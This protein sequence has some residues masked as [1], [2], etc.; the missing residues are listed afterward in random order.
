MKIKAILKIENYDA[1]WKSALSA[2][3]VSLNSLNT[4]TRGFN[5]NEEDRGTQRLRFYQCAKR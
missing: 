2:S 4:E 1:A 3:S 5:F